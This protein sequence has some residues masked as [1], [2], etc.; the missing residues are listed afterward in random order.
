M[1]A[2]CE[3]KIIRERAIA[4]RMEQENIPT[5]M[6]AVFERGAKFGELQTALFLRTSTEA[7][8]AQI[9]PYMELLKAMGASDKAA[10]ETGALEAM[11]AMSDELMSEG[12]SLVFGKESPEAVVLLNELETIHGTTLTE[13]RAKAKS[14]HEHGPAVDVVGVDVGE[15][16]AAIFGLSKPEKPAPSKNKH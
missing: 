4:K 12:L 7:T 16:L 2:I 10:G 1:C 6:R 14:P 3:R 11:A 5:E 15:L 13:A 8:I 9:Q